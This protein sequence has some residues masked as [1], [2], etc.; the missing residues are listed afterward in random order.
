MAFSGLLLAFIYLQQ[1]TAS[2]S[3]SLCFFAGLF[4]YSIVSRNCRPET[5]GSRRARK[6]SKCLLY[7]H[8][9]LR[10][11]GHYRQQVTN[12]HC[13]V[14]KCSCLPGGGRMGEF[15]RSKLEHGN[16]KGERKQMRERADK[17]KVRHSYLASY[18]IF[19]S[20]L[21]FFFYMYSF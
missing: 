18:L 15:E 17:P 13:E 1:M 16:R 9:L 10:V 7:R 21:C 11:E 8:H 3:F 12:S 4:V 6:R 2:Q 19:A 14:T 20:S 5:E